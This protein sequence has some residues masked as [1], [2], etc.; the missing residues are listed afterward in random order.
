M[1][2]TLISS[3]LLLAGLLFFIAGS[4]GMLRF[5]DSYSRL[6]AVTK[7]DSLGLGSVV[8][9]LM[10]YCNWWQNLLML[11]I[12]LLVLCSGTVSCQLLAR[13]CKTKQEQA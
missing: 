12:W 2:G 4:V 7:A 8:A 6:H 9:G 1:L 3:G 13:F 10:F 11:L 5:P